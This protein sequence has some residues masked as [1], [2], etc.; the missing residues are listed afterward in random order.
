MLSYISCAFPSLLA[1]L[2][3]AIYIKSPVI[4]PTKKQPPSLLMP[5]SYFVKGLINEDQGC[6][7]EGSEEEEDL[8]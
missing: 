5:W 1:S 6:L 3:I 4:L 8:I 2:P 7:P